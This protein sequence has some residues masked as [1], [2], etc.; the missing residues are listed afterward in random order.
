M[1]AI[2]LLVPKA[3]AQQK[4]A[5]RID[6]GQNLLN[7]P[8][9]SRDDLDRVK[10]KRSIWRSFNK[11]LLR[12]LF[13]S[14]ELAEEYEGVTVGI[15][16]GIS[17]PDRELLMLHRSIERDLTSLRA[18]LQKTEL[19]P[20]GPTASA[21]TPSA[22]GDAVFIVH[23]HAG[24]EYEVAHVVGELGPNTII[25]KDELNKGSPT[26]IQKLER[27]AERSGFAIVVV[28]PDDVGR[29]TTEKVLKPRARQ[30]VVLELGFF[31][32]KLGR[33]KV[34]ILHDPSVEIPSDFGGVAYYPLDEGGGWKGRIEGELRA[35][36]LIG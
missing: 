7:E 6:V 27:E 12:Q 28:T 32:A 31:A 24:R 21:S 9:Q 14:E 3:E 19:F 5:E 11:Q 36:G 13:S 29:A 33:D 1:S 18:I 2:L 25:L 30:N 15:G 10:S 8:I 22:A 34:I 35:A 16:G 23:G 26:L 17:S 4:I 20:E